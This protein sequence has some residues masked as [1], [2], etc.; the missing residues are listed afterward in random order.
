MPTQQSVKEYKRIVK[1]LVSMFNASPGL[2][3]DV[4]A[5]LSE[6]EEQFLKGFNNEVDVRQCC[7]EQISDFLEAVNCAVLNMEEVPSKDD[8]NI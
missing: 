3:F 1:T 7:V 6:N 5:G 8:N 4:I 2:F